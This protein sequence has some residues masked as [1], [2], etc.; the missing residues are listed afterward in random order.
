MAALLNRFLG[1]SKATLFDTQVVPA[2]PNNAYYGN[3]CSFCWSEYADTHE[4]VRVL[5]CNHVFGRDCLQDMIDFPNGHICP[6]CRCTWYR[7]PRRWKT[8]TPLSDLH[9]WIVLQLFRLELQIYGYYQNLPPF[10]RPSVYL[11]VKLVE[12]ML[13]IDNPYHW[14]EKIV[15]QWTNLY[16]RNTNLDLLMPRKYIKLLSMIEGVF[17]LF[18]YAS[19]MLEAEDIAYAYTACSVL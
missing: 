14:A 13:S 10:I 8:P 3:R 18:V 17:L 15:S 9:H 16:A 5:P 1:D 4:G 11:S 6:V 12:F 7:L 2:D 19:K